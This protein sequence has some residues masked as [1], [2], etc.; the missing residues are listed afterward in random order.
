MRSQNA[1]ACSHDGFH[2]IQSWYDRRD[3]VL[4]FYWTCERCGAWLG[5]LRREPYRPEFDP[6]GYVR[7]LTVVTH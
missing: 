3:G 6:H 1:V 2:S 4:V 5:E 7:F